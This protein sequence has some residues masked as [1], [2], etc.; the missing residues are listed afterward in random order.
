MTFDVTLF[1]A[2]GFTGSLT[3]EYLARNLP[4][5]ASWA[6]AGRDADKLE[7]LV[8]SLEAA[9]GVKPSIVIA[10]VSRWPT[11]KAMADN[12]R[13]L[14]STVGPYLQYGE[15]VVKAAAIAGI[16]YVDLT[17][18]P[19]FV[20]EMWLK[21]HEVAKASGARLVHACGFDSIPYDLGV[22]HTVRQL[23]QK[24]PITIR[25]YIRSQAAFSGGT[26]ASALNQMS[27][28]GG[29]K[30]AAKAR[31]KMEQRPKDRKGRGGGSIGAAAE[32]LQGWGAPLPTIDPQ[33]VLRSARAL[34]SYGPNF[35]YE[36]YAHFHKRRTLAAAVPMLAAV[37]AGSQ[38][39]PVRKMLGSM[40]APGDGPSEAQRAKSW[41]ELS[42]VAEAGDVRL[43]TVV[44]GGDP[45]YTETSKMLAESAMCLAFDKLPKTSG[46]LTTAMAMGPA[47]I[48]RLQHAGIDFSTRE[49]D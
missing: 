33:I 40:R 10:D 18:E 34:D 12:T 22:L 17:G 39:G 14:I 3:A 28:L 25:G 43:L 32:P 36:H 46:Q 2:T 42:L 24:T 26:Y 35:S 9:G 41:F 38:L 23:P 11:V 6:V 27:N 20:D 21:Y 31:R 45:G 4:F 1:G 48:T 5:G 19:Q 8:D 13:V 16:N 49:L 29:A 47:L 7:A 30:K 15:P 44:K 37:A